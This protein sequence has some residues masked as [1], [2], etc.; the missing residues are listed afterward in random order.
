[1]QKNRTSRAKFAR[2]SEEMRRLSV[3][4]EEELLQWPDV[5]ARSMFGMRAMYRGEIIFALLPKTKMIERSN[6][7][8]CKFA[9]SQINRKGKQW[10]LFHMENEKSLAEALQI[11]HQ[12][13]HKAGMKC[14]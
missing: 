4:L 1:M 5:S 14:T 11:L 13:H 9:G 3:L 12:A 10:Q 7:I 6:A 2:I 8:A